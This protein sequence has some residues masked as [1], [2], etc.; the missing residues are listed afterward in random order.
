MDA[1]EN[2]SF[3]FYT[4]LLF[5]V[6]VFL[7]TTTLTA[8]LKNSKMENYYQG[9]VDETKQIKEDCTRLEKEKRAILSDP[10]YLEMY[11]RRTLRMQGD[12]EIILK[13]K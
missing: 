8:H 3:F 4:A 7:L 1:A 5:L 12:G 13:S 11:I 9:L 6:M 2:Y 10:F